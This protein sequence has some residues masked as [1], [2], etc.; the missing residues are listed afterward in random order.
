[1]TD[2]TSVI[3]VRGF[4]M[5][6][7]RRL[8]QSG[9]LL[10]GDYSAEILERARSTLVDEGYCVTAVQIDIA[11]AESVNAFAAKAAD[12]GRVRN[13][14]CTAGISGSMGDPGRIFS[15]NMLGALNLLDAFVPLAGEGSVLIIIASSAAYM[16]PFSAEDESILARGSRDELTAMFER[17]EA[18]KSGLG[19]YCLAKRGNQLRVQALA[20]V[21]GKLG[22]RIVTVSPGVM[23]TPMS[24]FE[25]DAGSAI[26]EAVAN[27]PMGRYGHPEDIAAAVSWLAG[28]DAAFVTGIDLLVDGGMTAAMKWPGRGVPEI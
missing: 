8:G 27:N 5:P 1:M 7:C 22:A 23:A 4:G 11:D 9:R 6:I 20:P 2:V 19:T 15:V 3:G 10:I 18:A 24:Q 12:L 16:M 28:P 17:H 14:V 26:D 13:M 21:L 25:R